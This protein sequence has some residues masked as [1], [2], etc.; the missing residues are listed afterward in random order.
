[1]FRYRRW[2]QSRRGEVCP[3]LAVAMT[4]VGVEDKESGLGERIWMANWPFIDKV[5]FLFCGAGTG[6]Y[7]ACLRGMRPSQKSRLKMHE[8]HLTSNSG[9]RR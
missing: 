9:G 3:G 2:V 1:V 5:Q 6:G 7:L 4:V 8:R